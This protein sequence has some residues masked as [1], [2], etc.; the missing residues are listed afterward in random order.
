MLTFFWLA[1]NSTA[2]GQLA[3]G[4]TNVSDHHHHDHQ[5]HRQPPTSS[6]MAVLTSARASVGNSTLRLSYWSVNR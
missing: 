4:V 3:T 6:I 2:S 1:I 5:Q